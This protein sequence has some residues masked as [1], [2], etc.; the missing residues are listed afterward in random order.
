MIV[1]RPK[2]TDFKELY[3]FAYNAFR[4]RFHNDISALDATKFIMKKEKIE[5]LPIGTDVLKFGGSL[6]I[7]P[8]LENGQTLE[9]YRIRYSNYIRDYINNVTDFL[10]AK[11]VNDSKIIGFLK[12]PSEPF[13]FDNEKCMELGSIYVDPRKK[14]LNIGTKLVKEM[15]KK[16]SDI[17]QFITECYHF[18]HSQYFFNRLN[19][20][21][22]GNGVINDIYLKNDK[23]L[24]LPIK[25]E[26]MRWN[27][28]NISDV[29]HN[30][31]NI[32]DVKYHR[33]I[34]G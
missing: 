19:A 21:C 2:V 7:F 25:S 10:V 31:F 14:G 33:K 9:S 1:V 3:I 29:L 6:S 8:E 16:H 17:K 27:A 23:L 5:K 28:R 11:D 4:N 20:S 34:Y 26:I 32:P 22:I 30:N 13:I 24:T 15:F 12:Y 18:N